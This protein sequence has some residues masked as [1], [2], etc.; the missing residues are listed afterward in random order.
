MPVWVAPMA[1]H[2]LAHE[3][4]EVATC[5]AAAQEGVPFVSVCG[6]HIHATLRAALARVRM[7]AVRIVD[8]GC[9]L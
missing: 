9:H 3:G 8:M 6:P 2:G 4:R 7:Q 1:M 5:S